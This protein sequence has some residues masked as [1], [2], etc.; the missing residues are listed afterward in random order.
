MK[1]K[2]C[3]EFR[4]TA[5]ARAMSQFIYQDSLSKNHLIIKLLKKETEKLTSNFSLPEIVIFNKKL[6]KNKNNPFQI[7]L[8]TFFLK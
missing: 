5:A 1:K 7:I 2:M 8:F 3:A 4:R 6:I